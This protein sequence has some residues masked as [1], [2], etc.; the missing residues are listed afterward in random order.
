ML[1]KG[2]CYILQLLASI[3]YIRQWYQTDSHAT[4]QVLIHQPLQQ[5]AFL[6]LIGPDARAYFHVVFSILTTYLYVYFLKF[7]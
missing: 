2:M 4:E 7:L 1:L 3:I 5:K 6:F